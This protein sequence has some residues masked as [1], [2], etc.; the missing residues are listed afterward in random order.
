[1][2]PPDVRPRPQLLTYP[3]S[4]GGDLRALADLLDGP[5]AGL[6]H[7]VHVLPPFP[8]SGDRGFAPMTYG[9]IDRAVR[10]LGGHRAAS[11]EAHDVL[12]DLMINHISRQ[13]PEFQDFQRQRSS[14]RRRRP[15]HHARQGLAGRRRQ[16]MRTSRR[17]SC[18]S[19]NAPF[20]TVTIEE[21]GERGARLDIVR[22]RGLVRADRPRRHLAG[23][24]DADHAAG[25]ATSR[26][27]GVHI[28]RLDA[29]GYV[30]KK[31]GTNCFMVEPEIYD[32]LDWIT[33]VADILRP[34]R[35]ARGPRRVRDA[36]APC[37]ARL[38]DVRLRPAGAA[39]ADLRHRRR[40]AAGR[41][42]SRD[43]PSG[44][45]RTST[46]TT[47]SR[48]GP[49]STGILEPA[50][51]VDLADRIQASGRQ[52]QPDPVRTRTL[53]AVDVHQLNCTYYSALDGDDDRYVAARAIQLFARGVPQ[54]YYVGLL[55]GEN[56]HAAVERTGDGRSINRHDF[57]SDE[58]S[59][60]LRRPVV[61]RAAR[62][63]ATP[64]H[65][66]GV[67]RRAVRR[68]RGAIAPAPMERPG[69]GHAVARRRSRGRS[70][71]A[72]GP[73]RP[74]AD[75]GLVGL[76][77]SSPPSPRARRSSSRRR[78]SARSARMTSATWSRRP[79]GTIPRSRTSRSATRTSTRP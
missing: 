74:D 31:P 32:F 28:V 37:G 59:R 8:S 48:S 71:C 23:D 75:R 52:R 64:E 65:A 10:D 60:A 40:P 54:I 33:G 35:P 45:S 39:P 14:I 46:A 11:R 15:V 1:M 12:L 17:S 62:P 36:R 2:R 58:I 42:I 57:S 73:G 41:R 69:W 3:D 7:G 21:T 38:L 25:C 70:S 18:A 44:S 72:R 55:A 67:R 22:D 78:R 13:S 24:P 30:I 68:N 6:F 63:G 66:P 16:R 61:R 29:V 56:D 34:G 51:M 49:T 47:G 50:E 20:S 4:L 43:L 9:E 76:T 27:T 19:P 77:F 53:T 79:G 5:L 26:R